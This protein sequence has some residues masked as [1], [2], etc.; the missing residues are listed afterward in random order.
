MVTCSDKWPVLSSSSGQ[1]L[2]ALCKPSHCSFQGPVSPL[3]CPGSVPLTAFVVCHSSGLTVWEPEGT[4]L[5][6]PQWLP[7]GAGP[8]QPLQANTL[9]PQHPRPV[10]TMGLYPSWQAEDSSQSQQEPGYLHSLA[11]PSQKPAPF[12]STAGART[13][14]VY[15]SEPSLKAAWEHSR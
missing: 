6:S 4:L 14:R 8:L 11:R 5:S 10:F 12:C 13:T 2:L 3:Y 1:I 7:R 15:L 9:A